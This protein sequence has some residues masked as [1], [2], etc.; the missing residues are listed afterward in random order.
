MLRMS[1]PVGWLAAGLGCMSL[2]A[3]LA[4][5][6]S[7]E[8]GMAVSCSA[9]ARSA[10]RWTSCGLYDYVTVGTG[11]YFE[12]EWGGDRFSRAD[13]PRKVLVARG[14]PAGLETARVAAERGHRVTLTEA[15]DRLG[16]QLR[17]AGMQ[18][19][20]GQILDLIDWYERQLTKLQ[21]PMRLNTLV[22]PA[23]VEDFDPD[24]VILATGSQPAGNGWQRG[25]PSVDRLPGVDRSNVFPVEDVMSPAARPGHRVIVLDDTGTW[26][27]GGTAWHLAER[28]HAITIVT[29]RPLRGTRDR[30]HLGGLAA[31]RTAQAPGGRVRGGVRDHA[32]ARRRSDGDRPARR[33]RVQ[34]HPPPRP[35]HH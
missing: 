4:L 28:G 19:R 21:V 6:A 25:L 31:A 35:P 18:P 33:V 17:L 34:R 15:S 8:V 9:P 5:S 14:G 30:A 20:R 3:V 26:R 22:E 11:S 12:F 7:I 27:G 16:G 29:P 13:A 10:S 23:E 24:A 1:A 2:G 32:V